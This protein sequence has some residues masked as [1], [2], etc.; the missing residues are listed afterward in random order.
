M[1]SHT[2]M[3]AVNEWFVLPGAFLLSLCWLIP[4]HQIPWMS[5]HTDASVSLVLLVPAWLLLANK[6]TPVALGSLGV[7]AVFCILSVWAQYV[8][9]KIDSFGMAWIHSLYLA[10]F[11]VAVL[12]GRSWSKRT[13]YQCDDFLFYAVLIGGLLSVGVQ[14]LQLFE[15]G[16]S[17]GLAYPGRTGRHAANLGQPNQLGTLLTLG[18]VACGWFHVRRNTNGFAL[19]VLAMLLAFG[20]AMTGSRTGWLNMTALVAGVLVF[21]KKAASR[22]LVLA[23]LVLLAFYFSM[24]F[25]QPWSFI[26]KILGHTGDIP[27]RSL[28]DHARLNIWK[29]LLASLSDYFLSGYGWGQIHH[30]Q[31]FS[32]NPEL[33]LGNMVIQ[34]HNLLLD[35]VLWVGIPFSAILFALGLFWLFEAVSRTSDLHGYLK[36]CFL[37][38]LFVHSMLE[39]PLHYAYFLLPAGLMAGSIGAA[40]NT[41]VIK[42]PKLAVVLLMVLSTAAYAITVKDYLVIEDGCLGLRLKQNRIQGV[43]EFQAD[44]IM[45]LTHLRDYIAFS[46]NDPA[47]KHSE[48][49]IALGKQVASSFPSAL[50]M[51][52]LAAALAFAG[53]HDEAA[54]WL[55]RICKINNR[56]QCETIRAYWSDLIE[57]NPDLGPVDF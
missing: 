37:L 30:S 11:L 24:V 15:A 54:F 20:L 41:T 45:A 33:D 14:L 32:A 44:R 55:D 43:E 39:F 16:F 8:S 49:D 3:K 50:G 2:N 7:A 17:S 40:A 13:P 47:L 38:V 22:H 9:G 48:A 1:N 21:R 57:Q 6:N 51:Y 53:E 26:S 27:G 28:V 42:V 25:F 35:F 52:K 18:I 31:I 10:G 46:S 56:A 19:M 23:A 36:L 12:T 29:G 4:I 34:S 5:F